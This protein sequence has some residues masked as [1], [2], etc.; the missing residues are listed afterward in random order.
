MKN[1]LNITL[2]T[3]VILTSNTQAY[4]ANSYSEQVLDIYNTHC[5]TIPRYNNY[6]FNV[7]NHNCKF[8]KSFNHNFFYF[9]NLNSDQRLIT[10]T[11]TLLD[12]WGTHIDK[13][14]FANA[15]IY[16]M[17]IFYGSV[18]SI[19]VTAKDNNFYS[20]IYAPKTNK[21]I[22]ERSTAPTDQNGSVTYKRIGDLDEKTLVNTIIYNQYFSDT[23]MLSR[24]MP[25]N[26]PDK[27]NIAKLKKQLQLQ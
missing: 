7:D 5:K 9:G 24:A 6:A 2:F 13:T 4:A 26:A 1:K 27:I 10:K 16:P 14:S 12:Q 25:D 15:R 18:L 17:D 21:M 19:S 23:A 20:I 3:L 11:N 8:A 22:I